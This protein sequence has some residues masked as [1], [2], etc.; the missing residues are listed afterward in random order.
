[1][2]LNSSAIF[3]AEDV[4]LENGAGHFWMLSGSQFGLLPPLHEVKDSDK[5]DQGGYWICAT[6]QLMQS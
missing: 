5:Q 6:F 2:T 1:M 4:L 3:L